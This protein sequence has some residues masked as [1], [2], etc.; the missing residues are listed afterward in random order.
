VSSW[1]PATPPGRPSTSRRTTGHAARCCSCPACWARSSPAPLCEVLLHERVLRRTYQ[2]EHARL[3]GGLPQSDQKPEATPDRWLP[4]T[5]AE[6]RAHG[7]ER[8][9]AKD[10]KARD[11][12][13]RQKPSTD[14]EPASNA[15]PFWSRFLPELSSDPPEEKRENGSSTRGRSDQHEQSGMAAQARVSR[16]ASKEQNDTEHSDPQPISPG[17]PSRDRIEVER[18]L[19]HVLR[20]RQSNIGAPIASLRR[21][22]SA[23]G[24]YKE[25]RTG[26]A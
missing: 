24:G 8:R 13:P 23:K 21:R 7:R 20:Y 9:W 16:T 2:R 5:R 1:S 18:R 12:A 6:L 14:P 3:P 22:A 10:P 15:D 17:Y 11:V 19:R 4:I 25:Q 26:S